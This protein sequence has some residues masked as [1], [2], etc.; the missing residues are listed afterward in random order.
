MKKSELDAMKK[1]LPKMNRRDLEDTCSLLIDAIL[2]THKDMPK[3]IKKKRI[4]I[5]DPNSASE[6]FKKDPFLWPEE[7]AKKYT[8]A[9]LHAV[10]KYVYAQTVEYGT[11]RKLDKPI[12]HYVWY[13]YSGY[14]PIKG[15]RL[16]HIDGNEHNNKYS[17]LHPQDGIY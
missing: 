10:G 2:L 1:S 13:V 5:V 12:S 8:N 17:N 3:P 4:R 7:V 6:Q 14:F 9:C 16:L 11:R 15:S